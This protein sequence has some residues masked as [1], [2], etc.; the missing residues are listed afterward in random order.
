MEN[1]EIKR[2]AIVSGAT[3]GIGEAI[4]AKLMESGIGV[5]GNGRTASKLKKLEKEN[6][7]MFYAV[8]GDAAEDKVQKKMF[9]TAEKKF[10][11]KASIVVVNAGRGL[12][13]AVTDVNMKEFRDVINI[14]LTGALSLIQK[15]ANDMLDT[16]KKASFPENAYD[17]I[18][19]GSV[20]GRNISPFSAAYGASKFA[21]HSIT[22]SLR[23]QVCNKGIR[24]TLVE[25]AIVISG[26]Q[27]G[28]GYSEE[29]VSGFHE[30]W[31]PVL[32]PKD[33]ARAVGF[34][35]NQPSH[36]HISDIM[37]RPTR[38]DYP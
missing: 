11:M 18:V 17:I 36:V 9:E 16:V 35:V 34:I 33:I 20:V 27:K 6:P 25:P 2:V 23:R 29:M 32:I 8:A 14:N 10:D 12:E 5:I 31:G 3:S 28:A 37:I 24:V 13:G 1:E 38:Q 30:K 15:A 22:E 7:G 19:I 26:F 21:I 4:A